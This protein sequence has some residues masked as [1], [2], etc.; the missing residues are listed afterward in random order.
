[1]ISS[2]VEALRISWGSAS[3]KFRCSV[4]YA[5]ICCAHKRTVRFITS[6]CFSSARHWFRFV[7]ILYLHCHSAVIMQ[8]IEAGNAAVGH[9]RPLA[10]ARRNSHRHPQ[11]LAKSC[12]YGSHH[13][14]T[15]GVQF[16]FHVK[17]CPELRGHTRFTA[18]SATLVTKLLLCSILLVAWETFFSV[19][20]PFLI[21]SSTQIL[22]LGTSCQV[23]SLGGGW[24]LAGGAAAPI[25]RGQGAAK[26]IL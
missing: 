17:L 4:C 8:L 14:I 7:S 13:I 21:P 3:S 5:K 22:V 15:T 2:L 18:V 9:A 26:R 20:C 10:A 23:C 19:V 6:M 16:S 1:M 12:P 11:G 25:F 24:L